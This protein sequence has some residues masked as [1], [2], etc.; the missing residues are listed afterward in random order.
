MSRKAEIK[1]FVELDEKKVP[2]KLSWTASDVLNG[3]IQDS[4]AFLLNIWDSH[5]KE[6]MAMHLW[7]IKMSIDE[8]DEFVFQSLMHIADTYEKSTNRKEHAEKIRDKALEIFAETR[9]K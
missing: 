5:K 6:T 1:L 7:E 9:K 2:K 8:M 4:K 3:K